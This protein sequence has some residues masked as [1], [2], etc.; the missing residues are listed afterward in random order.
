M[1]KT[2]Q[3]GNF[4][5]LDIRVKTTAIISFL[6]VWIALTFIGNNLLE[7]S[8]GSA[9]LGGLLAASSHW[10]SELWH[11]LGHSLA[12]QRTGYPML[13]VTYV[14]LLASSVYPKNEPDLPAEI[15]IQHALGGPIASLTLGLICTVSAWLMQGASGLVWYLVLFCLL[16]NLLIFT[17]GALLPLGFTDGSTILEWWPKRSK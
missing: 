2:Y 12:A 3:L 15:H 4:A 9:L 6:L 7:L 14:G 1:S 13:G 10:L 16:N 11:Q 5:G 8:L 17:L